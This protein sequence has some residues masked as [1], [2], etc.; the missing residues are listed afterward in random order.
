MEGNLNRALIVGTGLFISVMIIS[1]A[2]IGINQYTKSYQ[3]IEEHKIGL[4]GGFGELEKYNNTDLIGMDGLNTAKKYWG[5]KY[6]SVVYQ[7]KN[8]LTYVF[9]NNISDAQYQSAVTQL[10]RYLSGVSP[11]QAPMILFNQKCKSTVELVEDPTMGLPET[12]KI[13]AKVIIRFME[14]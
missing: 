11:S 13:D 7:R 2:L 14:V 4:I 5:D 9:N 3:L 12:G 6:V 10:E 8:G 1:A